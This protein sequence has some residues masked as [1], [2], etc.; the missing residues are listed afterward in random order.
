MSVIRSDS[1]IEYLLK[2]VWFELDHDL[3][4]FLKEQYLLPLCTH[5]YNIRLLNLDFGRY[6]ENTQKALEYVIRTR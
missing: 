2:Y 5:R 3:A 4:I 6:M 1:Y